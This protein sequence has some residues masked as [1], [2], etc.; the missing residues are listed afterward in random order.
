MVDGN[1]QFCPHCGL[2]LTKPDTSGRISNGTELDLGWAKVIV[3]DRLGEG[4]MGVVHRGWLYYNPE[5][6]QGGSHPH[7]VAV[8]ALHP[9]LRGR[10]R[11]RQLFLGE[12]LALERLNHPNIVHFFGLVDDGQQLAIVIELVEGQ[13]LSEIIARRA[14]RE[15]SSR[16][17]CLPFARAWHYFSQLLGALASIHA[18]G[19]IH[20]DVKPANV[21]I[22]RDGMVKLTDFGIARVPA[23]QARKTGGMAP[24]TGAYMSPEQVTAGDIDARSDLYSAAIVLYEMLTGTTPFDRPERNEIMIRTAQLDE[25][26]APVSH[27]VTSAPPVLDV[28]MAR[29]LA[30][31][32]AL[33]FPSA[34]ELGEAFRAALSLETAGWEVQQDFARHARALSK[35]LEATP[36]QRPSKAASPDVKEAGESRGGMGT[37]R[38]PQI[39][40]DQSDQL[41]T[42]MFAAYGTPE[43]RG[44]E[45]PLES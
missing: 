17:P 37:Q 25:I 1:G 33:R 21:L 44:E 41:R 30:K 35:Q 19:I 31:D 45:P 16:L 20:R 3:G 2:A 22:R 34:I 6:P 11:P 23:D 10:D 40:S 18:M 12:A 9:M 14:G 42:A 26:P 7:P 24:G 36:E 8:K 5:G 15:R 38:L 32:K 43:G 4:G 39:A 13:A 29:A 28:L 27:H